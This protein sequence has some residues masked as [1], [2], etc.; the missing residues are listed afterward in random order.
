MAKNKWNHR[1]VLLINS[2]L[3]PLNTISVQRAM[4]MVVKGV[5]KIEIA[6]PEKFYTGKIWDEKTGELVTVDF[7]CPSVIRL[8]NYRFLPVRLQV[9]NNKNIF[10]R[11]N[12]RCQY[13]GTKYPHN[14]LTVDHIIPKSRGGKNIWENLVTC[15]QH[16]NRYK[17]DRLLENIPDM[18]LIRKPKPMTVHTI[19]HLLRQHGH[20][21]PD[22]KNIYILILTMKKRKAFH[23]NLKRMP[24]HPSFFAKYMHGE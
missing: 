3:E 15:C 10:I 18:C 17:D 4:K 8:L 21:E 7:F 23:H 11:D 1:T 20:V 2:C 16:C 19:K 22:W 24:W 6:R 13:C 9:P 12:Y 5:A 14:M